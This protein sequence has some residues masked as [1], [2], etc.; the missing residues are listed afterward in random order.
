[1][2]TI[3]PIVRLLLPIQLPNFNMLSILILSLVINILSPSPAFAI[4][5]TPTKVATPSTQAT[6]SA[7]TTENTVTEDIQKIRDAVKLKVQEKLKTITT[8][9]SSTPDPATTK[10]AIVG[11]IIQIDKNN[12]TID[13]QNSTRNISFATDTV[14][15]NA[16]QIKVKTDSLKV[17]Q[18]ILAMGYINNNVLTAKRIVFMDLKAIDTQDQIVVGK[19]VDISKSSPIIVLIPS[20]NK[21]N[22][23]QIK[24][25]TKTEV[26]NKSNQKFD[27][28][29]L[30]SGQ[31][32]IV[33]VRPDPKV[34]KTY[35]ATKIINIDANSAASPSATP[36][37]IKK[38]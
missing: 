2:K 8:T 27:I 32:V 10:K 9:D 16:K 3:K 4:T 6:T 23:Y 5:P 34:A 28:K 1:M 17:G 38:Q 19:I 25:D 30:V 21:N 11:T 20:K 35:L 7:Q 24:T 26:V 29:K 15:I 18:D 36:T 12:L 14:I 31:K 22:Q 37:A 33:V 13:Y